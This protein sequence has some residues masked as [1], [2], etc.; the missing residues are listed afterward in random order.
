[1]FNSGYLQEYTVEV[2]GVGFS[3]NNIES[4]NTL[5][6]DNKRSLGCKGSGRFTWLR[7]FNKIVIDSYVVTGRLHVHIEFDVNY[8]G[9]VI[10]T[11]DLNINKNKTIVKFSDL[12][13]NFFSNTV[14]GRFIDERYFSTP[15]EVKKKNY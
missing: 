9:N 3:D 13:K 6:S 11:E 8:E 5:W 1:M 12:N 7:V 14:K 2:D 15:T 10:K 4:F